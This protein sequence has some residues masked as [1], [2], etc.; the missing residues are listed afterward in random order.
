M[1]KLWENAQR[2]YMSSKEFTTKMFRKMFHGGGDVVKA[3]GDVLA[4][5]TAIM[6]FIMLSIGMIIS[7]IA[8]IGLN[9]QIGEPAY[10][11]RRI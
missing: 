9:I 10:V 3:L 11:N 2:L 6:L 8:A 4:I 1:K 5:I 7:T